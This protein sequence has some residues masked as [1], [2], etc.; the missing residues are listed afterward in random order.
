MSKLVHVFLSS[1]PYIKMIRT[2]GKELPFRDGKYCTD[3]AADIAYI[4]KEIEAGHP[5]IRVPESEDQRVVESQL[6]DP[7]NALRARIEQEIR[8][9][10]AIENATGNM[11][12]DMGETKQE[13]LKPASSTDVASAM[14][15]GSGLSMTARLEALKARTEKSSADETNGATLVNLPSAQ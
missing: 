11:T 5:H 13:P 7:M 2:D 15:G 8:A 10:I 1:I 14:L 4:T 6:L 12:K 9:Q 3:D